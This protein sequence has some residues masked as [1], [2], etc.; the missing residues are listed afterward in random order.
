MR[1]MFRETH[2]QGLADEDV[3]ALL[4]L[5]HSGNVHNSAA[6]IT[7]YTGNWEMVEVQPIEG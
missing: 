6:I 7:S 1:G 4:K 2:R 3:P 5:W